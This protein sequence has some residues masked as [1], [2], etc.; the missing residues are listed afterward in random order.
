MQSQSV[1][2]YYKAHEEKVTKNAMGKF[3]LSA[4]SLLKLPVFYSMLLATVSKVVVA[5]IHCNEYRSFCWRRLAK[6]IW[7]RVLIISVQTTPMR[8][9][10]LLIDYFKKR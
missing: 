8:N 5:K 9:I 4:Q 10:H 7:S 3:H 1:Q 6:Y 2:I